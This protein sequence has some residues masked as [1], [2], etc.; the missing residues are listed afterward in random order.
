MSASTVDLDRKQ[1]QINSAK[2]L[3]NAFAAKAY[4]N[5]DK[6]GLSMALTDPLQAQPVD[7]L[8]LNHVA[9]NQ[10]VSHLI[11]A[12][13]RVGAA[14]DE[15]EKEAD[16]KASEVVSSPASKNMLQAKRKLPSIDDESLRMKAKDS[17]SEGFET[18]AELEKRIRQQSRSGSSLPSDLRGF[19][20]KRLQSDFTQVR[21]HQDQASSEL[22]DQI[23][24]Q[25][26]TH[27]KHVF[28]NAGQFQPTTH[29]GQRLLAHELTH[30]VQQSG[31]S[32]ANTV[33]R[34]PGLDF[35][36][37]KWTALRGAPSAPGGAGGG[38]QAPMPPQSPGPVPLPPRPQGPTSV[39]GGPSAPPVPPAPVLQGPAPLPPKPGKP[40]P[41]PPKPQ[42]PTSVPQG[43]TPPPLPPAPVLKGPAPL[44][45]KPGKP[46]PIPPKPQGPTSVPQGPTPPPLP[47]APVLKGPAPL[48]PKPGKPLPIP[49][50]PGG[51]APQPNIPLPIP[52]KPGGPAPKPKKP[53]P[54]PPTPG[55]P[56]PQPKKPLP[57]PPKPGGPAPK[58]KKPLPVPPT[59]GGPVPKPPKDYSKET[60][61]ERMVGKVEDERVG[62]GLSLLDAT[63]QSIGLGADD[64]ENKSERDSRALQASSGIGVITGSAQ[65][66]LSGASALKAGVGGYRAYQL[67]KQASSANG[68]KGNRAQ[69]SMARRL[70][71]R[72]GLSGAQAGFGMASGITGITSSSFG[73]ANNDD[74]SSTASGVG[75]AI[76][77]GGAIF[78]GIQSL[79]SL[80][81]GLRRQ[82][83][84]E[85]FTGAT[86]QDESDPKKQIA[87]SELTQRI[88]QQVKENQGLSRKKAGFAANLLGGASGI[89][90][91]AKGFGKL[92]GGAGDAVGTVG[93][94]LGLGS[95]MLSGIS[96]MVSKRQGN[97]KVEKQK[98]A[99]AAMETK[100][101]QKQGEI[102]QC[103][104]DIA[105]HTDSLAKFEA[106]Q[107]EAEEKLADLNKQKG[108]ATSD[109]PAIEKQIAAL[110]RDLQT[111]GRA[112]SEVKA[113]LNDAKGKLTA[114]NTAM[115][116]LQDQKKSLQMSGMAVDPDA[117]AEAI[118]QEFEKPDESQIDKS[119][120]NFVEKVLGIN[121]P[122]EFVKSD[123]E[124]AQQIIKEKINKTVG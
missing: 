119:L 63:G 92:T 54:V 41:I 64:T 12:K 82:K 26:F 91:M 89:F 25:A 40:L 111:V 2:V 21:I 36:R 101:T 4:G 114:A 24:A 93:M 109:K 107:K 34:F 66:L 105:D 47:P 102:T 23:N 13:L 45:P 5:S 88:A 55:S 29:A 58:P 90:G 121:K 57:I 3:K 99:M 51:P 94:L 118:R 32:A 62:M 33:Q 84:A 19:M 95:S 70:A 80:H 46:L 16:R 113:L 35:L 15:Y 31:G 98:A 67:Y 49:P 43:P 71:R 30:V 37:K 74:A 81:S 28:F 75:G 100:I 56:V 68:G 69:M 42:G 79:V 53:L 73:L 96:S 9:G 110:T 14:N 61:L 87:N 106:S 17:L 38:V 65:T 60:G 52:P 97:A 78:G 8:R 83:T 85:S 10:A 86:R 20:E 115:Q 123:P 122:V 117:A 59:P 44:P 22:N 27:G 39:P 120:I 18:E 1:K 104:K 77:T 76:S 72:S 6:V 48:P 112:I 7:L 108:E 11:Q 50:K 116:S 103:E 124:M